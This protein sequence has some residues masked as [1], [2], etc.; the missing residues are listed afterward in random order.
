MLRPIS[1]AAW[2]AETRREISLICLKGAGS[3]ANKAN[4]ENRTSHTGLYGVS[5]KYNEK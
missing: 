3:Q 4:S 5:L 1:A 2:L